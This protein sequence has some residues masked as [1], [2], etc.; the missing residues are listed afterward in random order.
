MLTDRMAEALNAHL[1]AELYSAYL[2]L[3]MAAFYESLGLPGFASWMRVQRIE[4]LVH[5][6]VG[7]GECTVQLL[8]SGSGSSSDPYAGLQTW[9][10]RRGTWLPVRTRSATRRSGSPWT[11]RSRRS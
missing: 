2:Y 4:E 7:G 5:G 1:N 9:G 10:L 6:L 11:T 8:Q 3:S